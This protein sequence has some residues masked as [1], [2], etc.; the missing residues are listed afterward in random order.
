MVW[1]PR[2]VHGYTRKPQNPLGRHK[3][4]IKTG[5]H[6]VPNN[7]ISMHIFWAKNKENEKERNH[8]RCLP[9]TVEVHNLKTSTNRSQGLHCRGT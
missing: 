8:L 1:T 3:A 4:T 2:K 6:P 5:K 7:Q 9:Y